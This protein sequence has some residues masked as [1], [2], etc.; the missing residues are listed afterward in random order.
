MAEAY[1]RFTV[2]AVQAAAVLYERDE[3]VTKAARLIEEAAD[4]G[5]SIIGFPELY[6]PGHTTL[7]YMAKK[8]NPLPI[9]GKFF[10]DIVKN[11]VEVPGPATQQLCAAARK[12]HAYVVIGI[13]EADALYPG[14][15]YISQLFISNAGEIMGVHR[16]LVATSTEKLLYTTGDGSYL[17]VFDTQYGKLSAM[18]CGEHTHDLFKYALLAMGTQVHVA[19][20]PPFARPIFPQ[21]NRD[22]IDFRVRQFAHAGKIF[23]INSCAVTDRQNIEV[24][25][26]TQ[27][28][29]DNLVENSGGGSSIIG[30]AG[31]H[32]AGPI[33][34]GEAIV[35]A[36]ISLEDA[37]PYKQQHNVVG[38]YARWDVVS[39]NFNRE[40]LSPFKSQPSAMGDSMHGKIKKEMLETVKSIESTDN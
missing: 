7:W 17:N 6:V 24:C 11:A 13:S 18:N 40:K 29:K 38:H 9:Q 28:Q 26:D 35:T 14:T 20:W 4:R 3:T 15:L 23:V 8:S 12:S 2:A 34:D 27:E 19:S 25:C 33:H 30:P 5:A 16:K 22:A 1:Q 37:F 32:L 39:L 21:T 10:R 36:E 31:E